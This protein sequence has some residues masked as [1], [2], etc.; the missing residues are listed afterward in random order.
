MYLL[1]R[2][3]PWSTTGIGSLPFDDPE[4]AADHVNLAYDLP[5]C[6]QLPRV[7]GDM[8][9]EWLG[10][11]PGRCGWSPD[12]DRQRPLAWRAFLD[13]LDRRPSRHRIVKLQVT[14]PATL[15]YALERDSEDGWSR[16]ETVEMARELAAWLAANYADRVAVLAERDLDVL[17]V[18][19][20]PA[21]SIFGPDGID[22][23]WDPLRAVVP[24]WGF[25]FCC[26]VDW[27]LVER[28]EPDLI[29]FDLALDPVGGR[30]AT[31]LN[32]LLAKGGKVAWG[33]VAANRLES[34]PIPLGRLRTAL[35]AVPAAAGHSLVTASCGTGALS[36]A[37]EHEVAATVGNIVRAMRA[38]ELSP[39]G[40][41]AS[42]ERA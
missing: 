32:R 29:S 42:P 4:E 9:A 18:I 39:A 36:P 23:I 21:M 34:L 13:R 17:L 31:V 2:I 27:D 41:P 8:V 16:S 14:G 12:R 38:D 1:D 35:G 40:R 5:F 10:A 37:R 3:E 33:A 7:E 15:A 11:D 19:D 26:P 22:S 25:H 24:A 20:E 28:T 30:A 6:P